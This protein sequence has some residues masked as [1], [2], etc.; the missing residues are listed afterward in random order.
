[1]NTKWFHLFNLLLVAAVLSVSVRICMAAEYNVG[2]AHLT[3]RQPG[4]MPPNPIITSMET[5]NQQVSIEWRGFDGPFQVQ[6]ATSLTSRDWIPIGQ[7]TYAKQAEMPQE[8]LGFLRIT[9]A[10]PQYAGAAAC[11][12]CHR[13]THTN[14]AATGH[15]NAI[16][17]LRRVKQEKNA[18]CLPCHVVGYG[19]TTGYKDETTTPHLLGVQCENC[20]GPAASHAA[21]PEDPL[22][23]P[24][25]EISSN[26]CGGCH[27]GV[28]HPTYEEWEISGH[29]HVT[30]VAADYFQNPAS[31][32]SRMNSCGPCHSGSVRLAMLKDKSLPTGKE[33]AEM[34]INCVICHDP[35]VETIHGERL[36]NP[37]YSTNF[38][39][40]NTGTN[41]ASQYD[42]SV[43]ICGQCHNA[44]GARVADSSRPPHHSP[45]YNILVGNIGVRTNDTP[46]MSPHWKLPTQCAH[47]HMQQRT[48]NSPTY[49]NPNITGHSAMMT[50]FDACIQC[51]DAPDEKMMYTQMGIQARMERVKN[52]MD[53]W[54]NTKSDPAIR[55]KYGSLAWE[56]SSAGQISDPT[57]ASKGPQGNEQSLVPQNIKDARFNMYMVELD[58]SYGVHN[59]AY[60]RY[61]L[62]VAED[63]VKIELAQ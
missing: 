42:A 54:G 13:T 35:H 30:T 8:L 37:L 46:T 48:V 31:G 51:H 56:Y 29:I 14:W 61:L 57:G 43:N 12:E 19:L 24:P 1:M 45:Q 25:V 39:S 27:T 5:E 32:Q 38:F 40:Y 2:T 6:R 15:A 62:R 16:D 63:K 9:G 36:R 53:L 52:L 20:H 47:C 18:M 49:E 26:V 22:A 17:P 28:N 50:S 3:V 55:S 33:A 11:G 44:R 21:N 7:P 41:F 34:A 10:D 59:A 4:G 23:R 58:G 60:C